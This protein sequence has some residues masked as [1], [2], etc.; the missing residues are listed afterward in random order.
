MKQIQTIADKLN[1]NM[2]C[3]THSLQ[4]TDDEVSIALLLCHIHELEH[5]TILIKS[6]LELAL[7]KTTTKQ[8]LTEICSY[9]KK[10]INN[11]E[12]YNE[13]IDND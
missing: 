7:K 9:S 1:K 3:Y 13:E 6:N 11:M 2:G 8:E 5:L 4:P 10:L 12:F